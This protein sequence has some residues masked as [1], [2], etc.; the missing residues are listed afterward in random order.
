MNITDESSNADRSDSEI[1]NSEKSKSEISNSL[2][3]LFS[4]IIHRDKNVRVQVAEHPSLPASYLTDLA[5]D[6]A[7]EVRI[8]VSE[9][10]L[11]P[12]PILESLAQ[13]EHA[14]VRYAMAENANMPPH[15]LQSLVH[16]D[17]PYVAARAQKTLSRLD[18][19]ATLVSL[20]S[21][22]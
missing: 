2:L 11:T 10:L 9:N 13:D 14:D 7:H 19:D 3:Q 5:R 18:D 22:A 17:N 1:S 4:Q 16:D 12:V 21:C 6:E 15:I 8:A 20:R